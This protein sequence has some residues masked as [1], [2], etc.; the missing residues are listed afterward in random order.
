MC[1]CYMRV[2][3]VSIFVGFLSSRLL[4]HY[5]PQSYRQEKNALR[6]FDAD[7]HPMSTDWESE[8]KRLIQL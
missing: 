8:W 3:V 4:S 7:L 6:F 2:V 1:E 5:F